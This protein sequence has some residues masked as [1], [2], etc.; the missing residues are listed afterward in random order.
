MAVIFIIK[1]LWSILTLFAS[2]VVWNL[3]FFLSNM[4]CQNVRVA[5]QELTSEFPG[6]CSFR[7]RLVPITSFFSLH[8]WEPH[9][10]RTSLWQPEC[11]ER[12]EETDI[13]YFIRAYPSN[14]PSMECCLTQRSRRLK[15]KPVRQLT[16]TRNQAQD[17]EVAVATKDETT[18]TLIGGQLRKC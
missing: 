11:S 14:S 15:H 16:S 3:S 6:A 1:A 12:D 9:H 10:S 2:F 5:A 7:S 13:V 18:F 8:F 17:D 4:S